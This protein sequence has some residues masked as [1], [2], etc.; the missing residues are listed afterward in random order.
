MYCSIRN[1]CFSK[2]HTD[3]CFPLYQILPLSNIGHENDFWCDVVI[4]HLASV[5]LTVLKMIV[6]LVD[7][8]YCSML[9]GENC[10]HKYACAH[11]YDSF[12]VLSGRI[13]GKNKN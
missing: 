10:V 2:K 9:D 4:L 12:A 11:K 13:S 6:V 5:V 3:L 8:N 7:C 1:N